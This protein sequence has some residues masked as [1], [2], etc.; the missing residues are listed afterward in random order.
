[1]KGHIKQRGENSWAVIFD[2]PK[3]ELTQERKQQWVTVK[4]T[5]KDA[6]KRMHELMANLEKGL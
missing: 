3:N 4:G 6:E 5:R 1:M 2:L